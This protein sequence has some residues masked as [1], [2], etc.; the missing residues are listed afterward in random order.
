MNEKMKVQQ[1]FSDE[2]FVKSI[3]AKETLEE[4]QAALKEKGVDISI[5]ELE[6]AKTIAMKKTEGDGTLS[7]Q[8]LDS[9]AGGCLLLAIAVATAFAN[10]AYSGIMWYLEKNK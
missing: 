4:V 3:A 10:L 8:E 6:K 2:E 9:V 7:D 1:V 5:E